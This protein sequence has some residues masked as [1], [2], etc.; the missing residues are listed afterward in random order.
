M[1]E[2]EGAVSEVIGALLILVMVI[3]GLTIIMAMLLGQIHTDTIPSTELVPIDETNTTTGFHTVKIA[4]DGGDA[5]SDDEIKILIDGVNST[6]DSYFTKNKRAFCIQGEYFKPGDT[7]AFKPTKSPIHNLTIFYQPHG[8]NASSVVMYQTS[9]LTKV[10]ISESINGIPSNWSTYT[11]PPVIS[12]ITISPTSPL[13]AGSTA[14]VSWTVTDQIPYY[15]AEVRLTG[16]GINSVLS[17]STYDSLSFTVPTVSGSG[18]SLVITVRDMNGNVGTGTSNSF[19][20]QDVPVV[21]LQSPNGGESW[22]EKSTNSIVWTA[23]SLTGI[24]QTTLFLSKDGGSSW[25]MISS[26]PGSSPYSWT[27]PTGSQTDLGKINVTTCNSAGDCSSDTSDGVFQISTS[28][29]SG[30]VTV[31]SPV[32]GAVLNGAGKY[33][34]TWSVS[35]PFDVDSIDLKYTDGSSWT[36]ILTGISGVSSYDWTTPDAPGTKYQVSVTAY[37]SDGSLISGISGVFTIQQVAPTVVV[38]SPNG[39]EIW[40]IGSTQQIKWNATS[41]SGISS[42]NLLYSISDSPV[43]TT[44]ASGISNTGLFSW[45]VPAVPSQKV[46]IIVKA[47]GNNGLTGTDKSDNYFQ[48]KDTTAP[49]ISITTPSGGEIW[50]QN[51]SSNPKQIVWTAS[52]NV[53][54]DHIKLEYSINSGTSYSQI[55]YAETLNNIGYFYW[56]VPNNPSTTCKIRGTAY[57]FAGNPAT[58]VS[59]GV[60]TIKS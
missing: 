56:Y 25:S 23:S 24:S 46:R 34:I 37:M 44:I 53:N 16:P 41:G 58:A 30:S 27:I 33:P 42:V 45:P 29:S 9:K 1:K 43:T 8:S 4:H 7:L 40:S 49:T 10:N 2:K 52:D 12:S 13:K 18:Y 31:T 3:A 60:F 32:S 47:S 55:T 11:D 51:P 48:I 59:N 6:C 38:E 54:V 19:S 15:G 35:S 5:L 21:S 20:I 50:Q 28:S 22:T 39:G 57:D 14:T 36:P 26:S 17:S